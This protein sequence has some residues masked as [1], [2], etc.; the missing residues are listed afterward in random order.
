MSQ[1]DGRSPSVA[2]TV[3]VIGLLGVL[4]AALIANWKS[5]T[6]AEAPIPERQPSPING[7]TES[8]TRFTATP[9]AD[10]AKLPRAAPAAPPDVLDGSSAQPPQDFVRILAVS[11]PTTDV[12]PSNQSF[13]VTLRLQY[14]LTS[15]DSAIL[16][17]F[18]EQFKDGDR[19]ASSNH[20][21]IATNRPDQIP[22]QRGM[23]EVSVVFKV[24]ANRHSDLGDVGSVAPNASLWAGFD[25]QGRVITLRETLWDYAKY[26]YRFA[27]K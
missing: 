12:L 8:P 16:V 9:R 4:G 23:G 27:P 19:C 10:R 22:I 26:C 15:A 1:D 3:A 21:T 14:K 17:P 7:P 6:P 13:A 5:F 11:P 18:L 2:I 24:E 20:Q 25:S